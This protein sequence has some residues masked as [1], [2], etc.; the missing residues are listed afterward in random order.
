MIQ[1]KHNKE[2]KVLKGAAGW[3][4]GTQT[5]DGHPNCRISTD[6]WRDE[7]VART[8]LTTGNFTT[9]DCAM[10][11]VFCNGDGRCKL[12]RILTE[13]EAHREAMDASNGYYGQE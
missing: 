1:C 5:H 11:N 3:Y 7:A 12:R 9:R 6:Y 10:E 2:V 4:I 13:E 8:C